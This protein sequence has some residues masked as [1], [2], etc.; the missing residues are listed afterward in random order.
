MTVKGALNG[1]YRW[2]LI[3]CVIHGYWERKDNLSIGNNSLINNCKFEGHNLICDN[4]WLRK[5]QLG[6]LS[7][8]GKGT[9]LSRTKV[10][11]YSSIGPEVRTV[12]GNHPTRTKVAM[13]PAFYTPREFAGMSI[14]LEQT[15]E[16]FSYADEQKDWYVEIGNDVWIGARATILN[17]CKIGDGA[18]VAAGA[19]VTKDVPPYCIVGGVPA[20]VIRKRFADEQIAFLLEFKWWEKD[21][22]WLQ[23]NVEL[24]DDVALFVEKMK[25]NGQ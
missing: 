19:V 8:V 15:F 24:F 9:H 4:C 23:E 6:R 7:Y 17:G 10:G 21:P 5:S 20:K 16:E 14:A 1:L 3:R 12:A 22:A 25:G 11:R 18:I 13:H 2:K